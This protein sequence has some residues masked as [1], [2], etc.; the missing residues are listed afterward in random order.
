M[1]DAKLCPKCGAPRTNLNSQFCGQCGAEYEKTIHPQP[2]QDAIKPDILS[3]PSSSCPKC[4]APR[5]N[6]NSQFCGQCGAEYEKT[7]HPQ[8]VQDA[9]KPDIL[10]IPSSSCPK[11]GAPR[12]NVNSQ[13]CGQCGAE[14]EQTIHPQPVKDAVKPDILSKIPSGKKG[15]IIIAGIVI[16]VLIGFSLLYSVSS[17]PENAVIQYL[18]YINNGEYSQAVNLLVDPTTLQP[19]SETEQEG[20]A[21]LMKAIL[22]TINFRVSNITILSKQKIND[23]QYLITASATTS[24]N[25]YGMTN[26]QTTSGTVMV[27]KINGQWKLAENIAAMPIASPS[28][29]N[30][31]PQVNPSPSLTAS[32]VQSTLPN[33]NTPYRQVDNTPIQTSIITQIPGP[34]G[35]FLPEGQLVSDS[36]GGGQSK[37][38][39]FEV[40]NSENN[41]Q[42]I[43]I[44]ESGPG[45]TI[46]F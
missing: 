33:G 45:T 13:F 14:Y 35:T 34:T 42:H 5:T 27:V 46:I 10:S 37:I 4:G 16:I 26:Q 31:G 2:V 44:T 9:I 12:T 8:P 3:I 6:V 20:S 11:C 39:Y 40:D 23:N 32:P 43:D 17:Q 1:T 7:I 29:S 25:L 22:G 24:G 30:S 15:L 38:Y 28:G 19:Y 36:V 41:I 21:A 18:Q